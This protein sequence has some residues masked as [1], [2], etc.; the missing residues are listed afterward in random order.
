MATA[1]RVSL[2]E[3]LGSHYE[4]E[5]ELVG[6]ELLEKPMGTLEHMRLE[7]RLI[8]LLER[9]EQRGL[10]FVVHEL[11]YRNGEEVRIPDLVFCR[12]G[13]RFENDILIDAPLLAVEVLSSSQRPSEL[14]AKCEV[15]HEWG[16]PSC[17][18]VDPSKKT[19]W[20]YHRDQA[21][22]CQSDVLSAGE[23]SVSVAELFAE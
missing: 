20:E 1:T 7:R 13:S 3:Y 8:K 12:P 23:L 2:T 4:P 17:W 18:V 11:S 5:C 15:Y 21:V 10:G 14:F 16:V 9:F 6:G 22:S 19:A